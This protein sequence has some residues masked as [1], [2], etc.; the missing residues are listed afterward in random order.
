MQPPHSQSAGVLGKILHHSRQL[1][2]VQF[3]YAPHLPAT[4]DFFLKIVIKLKD[5]R[6]WTRL[7]IKSR[8]HE[9]KAAM[10]K[11]DFY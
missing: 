8:E 2:Q 11:Y 4:S 9:N 3:K 5:H 10:L 6:S 7:W 1:A